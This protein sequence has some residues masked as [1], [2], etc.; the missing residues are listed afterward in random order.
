MPEGLG[1]GTLEP[2]GSLF[3]A[4]SLQHSARQ[5]LAKRHVSGS[6]SQ[7]PESAGRV[8]L[9]PRGSKLVTGRGPA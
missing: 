4:G 6:S 5:Q 8:V 3:P 1:V 2:E 7:S 9:G